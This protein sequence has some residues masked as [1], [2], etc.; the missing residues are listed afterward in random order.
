MVVLWVHVFVVQGGVV[1]KVILVLAIVPC[2]VK[3]M[4]LVQ[5]VWHLGVVVAHFAQAGILTQVD[6]VEVEGEVEVTIA[7]ILMDQI[8]LLELCERVQL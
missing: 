4:G 7:Y 5:T 8:V 3:M 6:L 1:G 2:G